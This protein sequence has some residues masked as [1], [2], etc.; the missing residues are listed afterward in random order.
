MDLSNFE[1]V[2]HKGNTNDW[3]TPK[4]ILDACGEFDLDPCGTPVWPTA[5]TIFT[6]K[7]DGLTK[8]WFGRVWLNPPYGKNV[9]DWLHKLYCHGN[10]LAL[11]FARTDTKWFQEYAPKCSWILFV[12]GRIK[13]VNSETLQ[14]TDRNPGAPSILMAFGEQAIPEI[15]GVRL[16]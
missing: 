6:K 4:W 13:F 14:I 1:P 10:G 12:S 9:G 5:R 7:D 8:K 11:V 16:V 2:S 3:Y 15:K